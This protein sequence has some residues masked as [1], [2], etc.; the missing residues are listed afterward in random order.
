MPFPDADELLKGLPNRGQP[1]ETPDA[2]AQLQRWINSLDFEPATARE[3][4]VAE[5]VVEEGATAS[6][7]ARQLRESGHIVPPAVYQRISAARTLRIEYNGMRSASAEPAA[8]SVSNLTDE[9]LWG[10]AP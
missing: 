7:E 3:Q 8:A 5:M 2:E 1:L 9:P 10:A 6:L 4:A